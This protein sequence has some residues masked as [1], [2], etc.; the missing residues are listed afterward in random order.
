[1]QQFSGLRLGLRND[2]I[3]LSLCIR[4]GF[5]CHARIFQPARDHMPPPL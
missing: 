4:A 3:G 2:L 5:G 1:M